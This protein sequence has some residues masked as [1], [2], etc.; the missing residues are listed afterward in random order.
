MHSLFS[1]EHLPGPLPKRVWRCSPTASPRDWAK[2]G[3]RMQEECRAKAPDLAWLPALGGARPLLVRSSLSAQLWPWEH[4]PPYHTWAGPIA[5]KERAHARLLLTVFR[6][7]LAARR[8]Q[9][10][11]FPPREGAGHPW[12]RPC[13]GAAFAG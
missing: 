4:R 5:G 7:R 10:S 13:L 1:P 6:G 3:M 11:T 2:L 9:R 8:R 12:P